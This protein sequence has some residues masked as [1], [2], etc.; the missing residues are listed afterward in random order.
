M[1]RKRRRRLAPQ[2]ADIA[3]KEA[4]DKR[5]IK[6]SSGNAGQAEPQALATLAAI[7]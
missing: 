2:A 4:L 1:L 5:K 3:T 6:T 7:H